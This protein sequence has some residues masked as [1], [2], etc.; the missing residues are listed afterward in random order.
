MS[1]C[2][3]VESVFQNRSLTSF[4]DET[5]F[6]LKRCHNAAQKTSQFLEASRDQRRFAVVEC[7]TDR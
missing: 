1:L 7:G 5:T 3:D 6:L 4:Q 2:L